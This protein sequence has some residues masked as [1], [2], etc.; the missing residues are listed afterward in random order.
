MLFFGS[1]GGGFTSILLSILFKNSSAIIN[2]PQIFCK[3]LKNHYKNMIDTC[4]DQYDLEKIEWKYNY[5]FDIIEM[6][7]KHQYIPNI[8]YLIN[9][10]SE[11]DIKNHFR[12]FIKELQSLD[13]FDSQLTIILYANSNG[14][15]GVLKKEDTIELIQGHFLRKSVTYSNLKNIMEQNKSFKKELDIKKVR[16][17][18]LQTTRG[19]INYKIKN[20]LYRIKK[21]LNS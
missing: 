12:P 16:I 21:R 9:I 5:R 20:I 4:F 17:A 19:W 1:S 11:D 3:N 14:H 7:K 2:N 6:I 13:Y 15:N 8:T 10:L 18:E